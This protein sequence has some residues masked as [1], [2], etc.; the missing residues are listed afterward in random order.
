M[1]KVVLDDHDWTAFE[2][3]GLPPGHGPTLSPPLPLAPLHRG[4]SLRHPR[5]DL[6][7]CHPSRVAAP[8][9]R[10]AL[11]DAL[12]ARSGQDAAA[13]HRDPGHLRLAAPRPEAL[14]GHP[15]SWRD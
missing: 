2:S 5:L 4:T 13:S 6:R 3:A 11:R 1:V 10:G 8:A 7:A 9:R 15:G 12:P 14:R